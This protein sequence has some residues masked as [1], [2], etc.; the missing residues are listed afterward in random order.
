MATT[1]DV[2]MTV[3]AAIEVAQFF[4]LVPIGATIKGNHKLTTEPECRTE[5]MFDAVLIVGPAVDSNSGSEFQVFVNSM[6]WCSA[7]LMH[8]EHEKRSNKRP[9]R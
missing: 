4:L 2:A 9:A 8:F 6:E 1:V 7:G 3:A 5:L